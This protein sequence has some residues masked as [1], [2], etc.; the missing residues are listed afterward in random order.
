MDDPKSR[1]FSRSIQC[2]SST[3]M[4]MMLSNNPSIDA[5]VAIMSPDKG[6]AI[7]IWLLD[8]CFYSCGSKDW[9]GDFRSSVSQDSS[10]SRLLYRSIAASLTAIYYSGAYVVPKGNLRQRKARSST[11]AMH[12]DTVVAFACIRR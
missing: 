3:V 12:Y 11:I 7:A 2:L 5:S 8:Y 4:V 9:C 10:W 1:T 6:S